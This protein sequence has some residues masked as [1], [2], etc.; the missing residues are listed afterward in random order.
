MTQPGLCTQ[1]KKGK[2][3]VKEYHWSLIGREPSGV[4]IVSPQYFLQWETPGG[5]VTGPK[6]KLTDRNITEFPG[7]TS[8]SS[9]L[10]CLSVWRDYASLCIPV[11]NPFGAVGTHSLQNCGFFLAEVAFSLK[12][13][14]IR[15]GVIDEDSAGELPATM[16]V[17]LEWTFKKGDKI[18]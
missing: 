5:A 7:A 4:H 17:A 12:G 10:T 15:T 9:L 2:Y 18:A 14:S 11:S 13:V 3:W 1:C 6:T 8:S 16:T